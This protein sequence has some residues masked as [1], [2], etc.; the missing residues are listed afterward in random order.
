MR[1]ANAT[2]VLVALLG[3][4]CLAADSTSVARGLDVVISQRSIRING[5]EL[6]SG[7]KSGPL[8][9]ISLEAAEKVLG[10]PQDTYLAGLGVRVYAWPDAGIHVQRGFRGSD[11]GRIFKFQVWFHDSY[12]KAED[13]HSGEFSGHVL[14]DG[15]DIGSETTFDSIRGRLEKAGYQI[16]E[17]Q[18]VISATKGEI[19]IFTVDTTNKIGRVEAWCSS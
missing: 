7:L 1:A 4:K 14:V 18:H 19:S 6:R 8:R 9:Y 17:Y 13:K 2:V 3:W 16:I 5:V 15:L 11:E 10:R 12:D